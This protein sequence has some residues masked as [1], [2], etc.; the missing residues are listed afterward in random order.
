MTDKVVQELKDII[1]ENYVEFIDEGPTSFDGYHVIEVQEVD[2]DIPNHPYQ[3]VRVFV[4]TPSGRKFMWE[5][6]EHAYVDYMHR[7]PWQRAVDWDIVE[8]E[9]F[10]EV[11]RKRKFRPISMN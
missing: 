11:I 5:Y 8:V 6:E 10:T 3:R 9:E 4:S 2:S 1:S 7:M